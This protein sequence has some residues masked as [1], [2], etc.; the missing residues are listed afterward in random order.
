MTEKLIRFTQVNIHNAFT[1]ELLNQFETPQQIA[2]KCLDVTHDSKYLIVPTAI[3]PLYIYDIARAE[4]VGSFESDI[5]FRHCELSYG[6]HDLLLVSLVV[7][8]RENG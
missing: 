8:R 4:A 2:V 1:G 6:S 3:G 7:S 5:K